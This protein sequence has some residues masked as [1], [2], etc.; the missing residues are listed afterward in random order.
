MAIHAEGENTFTTASGKRY[1][2]TGARGAWHLDRIVLTGT[3]GEDPAANST[4]VPAPGALALVSI[5]GALLTGSR[6]RS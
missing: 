1:L 2:S 3:S 6:R 5:A 4:L